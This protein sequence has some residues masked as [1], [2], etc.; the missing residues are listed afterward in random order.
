MEINDEK[1]KRHSAYIENEI[2]NFE[3]RLISMKI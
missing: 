2:D 1:N 3:K